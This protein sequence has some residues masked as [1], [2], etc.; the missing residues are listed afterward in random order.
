MRRLASADGIGASCLAR[1]REDE[2]H[3]HL[4]G[5]GLARAVR[6]D[7]AEDLPGLHRQVEILHCLYA[8]AAHADLEG[9]GELLGAQ[10]DLT[11]WV[12]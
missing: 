6:T 3:E 5:G 1:R 2:T 11:H 10:D 9:L 7:E 12:E 4:D 8:L